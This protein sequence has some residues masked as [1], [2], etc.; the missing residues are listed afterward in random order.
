MHSS[1]TPIAL[2]GAIKPIAWAVQVNPAILLLAKSF[3]LWN[4]SPRGEFPL[5]EFS[6]KSGLFSYPKRALFSLQ[7]IAT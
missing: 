2:V 6:Q 5:G 7:P 1:M 3:P 4:F